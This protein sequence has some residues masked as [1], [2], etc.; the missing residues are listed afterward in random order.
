MKQ[1]KSAEILQF[2]F[3]RLELRELYLFLK[4]ATR[5]NRQI[6]L[7]S[8][9]HPF[10]TRRFYSDNGFGGFENTGVEKSA[11]AGCYYRSLAYA[12]L[13]KKVRYGKVCGSGMM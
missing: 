11:G 8:L 6:I 2:L 7:T 10:V 4:Y 12:D 1:L 3:P 13:S 9:F 5:K